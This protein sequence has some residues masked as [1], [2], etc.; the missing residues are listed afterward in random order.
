MLKKIALASLLLATSMARADF[1]VDSVNGN[2]LYDGLSPTAAFQ[3]IGRVLTESFPNFQ[4]IYLA[5]GSEWR[6]ELLPLSPT[7]SVKAY[8][9][10]KMPI[11]N[12]AD[13][14]GNTVFA[15]SGGFTNLYDIS[16]QQSG[17]VT[18]KTSFSVWENGRRLKA[19]T[20]TAIADATP[21]SFY[22]PSPVSYGAS[23]IYVHAVSSDSVTA[24]AK[25]YE[26]SRRL[27]GMKLLSDSS[28]YYVHTKFQ[29]H[30]D[31]S[32]SFGLNNYVKGCLFEDGT[33][34]NVLINSGLMEDCVAWKARTEASAGSSSLFVAY[35]ASPG[36]STAFKGCVA[37][38]GNP[39]DPDTVGGAVGF[40]GHSATGYPKSFSF[41][42]CMATNLLKGF[43]GTADSIIMK[44]NKTSRC[45][46]H[47]AL[48]TSVD[49]Y[50][51]DHEANG[52]DFSV[53]TL[54]LVDATSPKTVIRGMKAVAR[55]SSGSL[56]DQDGDMTIEDSVFAFKDKTGVQQV[57][58]KMLSGTLVSYNRNIIYDGSMAFDL[59]SG[60]N[61]AS[62]NNNDYYPS[63]MDFKV[64]GTTYA[65]FAAY[66]AALSSLD[67]ASVTG[68]P[69]FAADPR[70]MQFQLQSGSPAWAIKAGGGIKPDLVALDEWYSRQ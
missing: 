57:L 69:L 17:W 60:V 70:Q 12:A 3:T 59:A 40:Y 15:K 35:H 6:E 4:K 23:T 20:S 63:T 53:V 67:A 32:S 62:A 16:W 7:V 65:D 61:I 31:G 14:A 10:G 52:N 68:D 33:V 18:G 28:A 49:Q 66:R 13:V 44:G 41:E 21:A 54:R 5:R 42:N 34:H 37:I 58:L 55:K 1:Y 43:S 29:A 22:A 56:I 38:G 26:I 46:Y 64:N 30:N 24:N 51:F 8:G 39:Y 48:Y 36:H 19:V 25:V 50:I 27:Y 2:D 45:V 11:L 47:I 9:E